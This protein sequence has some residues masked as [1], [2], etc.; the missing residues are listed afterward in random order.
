M[1]R[2]GSQARAARDQPSPGAAPGRLGAGSPAGT[3]PAGGTAAAAATAAALGPTRVAVNAM[4][5]GECQR[6]DLA[7]ARAL[8]GEMAAEGLAPDTV[9]GER[10]RGGGEVGVK[11]G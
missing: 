8:V 10:D 6:G 1:R 5:T 9:R 3:P 7:A 2:R 11:Q 4:V